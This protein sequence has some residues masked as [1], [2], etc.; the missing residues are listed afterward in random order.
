MSREGTITI[1][2]VELVEVN[3][4][5]TVEGIASPIGS[6]STIDG[7][8]GY[9]G[10]YV[11]YG[12]ND[13]EWEKLL[14]SNNNVSVT[15]PLYK[16]NNIIG[17]NEASIIQ[18]GY[19]STTTQTFAGNK[20]FTGSVETDNSLILQ[21]PGIGTN[22]IILTAPTLS[23][24]WTMTLPPNSGTNGY[25]LK[26]N[27]TGITSWVDINST[28]TGIWE[29]S[30]IDTITT[31]STS[32][33]LM[34][35][36]QQT[37]LAGRYLVWF[38]SAQQISTANKAISIIIYSDGSPVIESERL[39][40]SASSN[41]IYCSSLSKLITLL[42]DGSISIYWKVQTATGTTY[43]RTLTIFKVGTV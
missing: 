28:I 36:M 38:S 41:S 5:P 14:T 40:A 39:F 29:Q 32:Y 37:L 18:D 11:K 2:E 31:T 26:T 35:N 21:D 4:D 13:T 12:I 25:I 17:I 19:I 8:D 43:G 34:T 30:A 20:I 10:V 9:Y 42:V 16:D 33:V 24:N 15:S 22:Q 3:K 27:G 23:T 1:N 6:L 7:T